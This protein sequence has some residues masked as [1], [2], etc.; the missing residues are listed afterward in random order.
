MNTLLVAATASEIKP[1][2]SELGKTSTKP[3]LSV[4]IAGIGLMSTTYRL[5]KQIMLNRPKL[6]IQAG[7]AGCFDP[8]FEMG[9]LVAVKR[10]RI[11]DLGVFEKKQ[12]NTVYD[13][14]LEKAS[15]TP[16]KNG[17]LVNPHIDLLK[18]TKLELVTGITISEIS[19]RQTMIDYYLSKFGAVV[20]SMEGAALHY[21]SL[22]EGIPFLQL[23]AVSNFVGERNKK[24]WNIGDAVKNLNHFL[25]DMLIKKNNLF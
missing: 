10:D 1:F 16:F 2:L 23:R 19:T 9:K 25:S 20:E 8:G 6:I 3:D 22:M 18:K 11:A 15:A 5:Q 21:V 13:L 24:K 12:W 17:W 4:L 14:G 7:I